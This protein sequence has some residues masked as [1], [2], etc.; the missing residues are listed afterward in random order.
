MCYSCKY[1]K[2]YAIPGPNHKRIN[3]SVCL[4]YAGFKLSDLLFN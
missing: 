1:A 2:S 3:V 4:S